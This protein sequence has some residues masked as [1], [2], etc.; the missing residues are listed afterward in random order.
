M[1]G[2]I[3]SGVVVLVGILLDHTLRDRS[4]RKEAA[5]AAVRRLVVIVP[6]LLVPIS[7]GAEDRSGYPTK[8]SLWQERSD[9][10]LTLLETIRHNAWYGKRRDIE[11]AVDAVAAVTGRLTLRFMAKGWA[12]L[13]TSDELLDAFER[14]GDL[15]TALVGERQGL[16]A[17][18]T[19]V[20]A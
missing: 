8:D 11:K 13:V 2:G 9:E 19:E 15:H 3:V 6:R 14:V 4:E 10:V 5:R 1:I 17:G 12:G 16:H 20:V 7:E 18:I